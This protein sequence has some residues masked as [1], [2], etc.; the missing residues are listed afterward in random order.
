MTPKNL[1]QALL[2]PVFLA[3]FPA[4]FLF[5]KNP[6][7][8]F[9]MDFLI[10][11]V[12]LSTLAIVLVIAIY[13]IG[14]KH[15]NTTAKN[16]EGEVFDRASN[17]VASKGSLL[18][19]A[20]RSYKLYQNL[21][22]AYFLQ[23]SLAVIILFIPLSTVGESTPYF[24]NVLT[25]IV[26]AALSI[27]IL[28]SP[29]KQRF[30]VIANSFIFISFLILICFHGF[31]VFISKSKIIHAKENLRQSLDQRFSEIKGTQDKKTGSQP[32]IYF[33]V[34]DEFVSQNTFSEYYHYDLKKFFDFLKN[35]GFQIVKYPYS[36]YPWTIPSVSSMVTMLYHNNLVEKKEFPEIA[37]FLIR[38][39][40]AGTLLQ[41]DGYKTYSLLSEYWLGNPPRGI[42]KDFLFRAKSYSLAM[43]LLRS[44]PFAKVARS[45]QRREH[46]KHILYQLDQLKRIVSSRAE[47]KFIFAHILCP[48]RPIVFDKNGHKL[49]KIDIELSE[50]D[51]DHTYYLGQAAYIANA[52][53]EVVQNILDSSQ[54]PPII[55][56][57][58][59]HGKFPIGVSGK[60]AKTMPL[61][62][63][64]WRFSNF[65]ALYLP[66]KERIPDVLTPINIFPIILNHYCGYHIELLPES[67]H[68][69]P[70]NLEQSE[71]T[72]SFIQ[73]QYKKSLDG[74]PS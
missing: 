69:D 61:E 41:S 7:E 29:P 12:M 36:N 62:V 25:W 30:L 55:V 15:N 18:S 32:D 47:K 68:T 1:I 33:I 38:Y 59:D 74:L 26:C 67:C 4:L 2:A 60:G 10:I 3:I 56:L 52:I 5:E 51:N 49:K 73:Y 24:H 35:R 65:I 9:F 43:S 19:W 70:F 8:V 16:E 50:K 53:Q 14:R 31:S 45:Y 13:A 17:K 58:S 64:S 22:K 63:L 23:C 71:R 11:E 42:W 21:N 57:L 72:S 44:T 48:H 20:N 40:F 6:G 28:I 39:N 66:Q 27:S 37:H 34:V 46:R 54:A